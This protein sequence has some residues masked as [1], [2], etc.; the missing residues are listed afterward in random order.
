[1][2]KLWFAVQGI[3]LISLV[4][5][6]AAALAVYQLNLI[7]TSVTTTFSLLFGSKDCICYA[8]CTDDDADDLK[9]SYEL[10]FG[11]DEFNKLIDT[12]VMESQYKESLQNMISNGSTGKEIGY[13]IIGYL[14]ED[15]VACYKELVGNNSGFMSS[16]G[17]DR[18]KMTDD[19]LMADLISLLKDYKSSGRN[20]E[21]TV[22]STAST[23]LLKVKCQGEKHY[24]EGWTWESLWGSSTTTTTT[25]TTTTSSNYVPG[26]ATGQYAVKLVDGMY[27]W[28]HQSSASCGCTYCGTWSMSKWG[29]ASDVNSKDTF[30]KNGCAVY[31]LAIGI[32][33]LVGQEITPTV[34]LTDLGCEIDGTN[35]KTDNSSN[36]TN[37]SIYRRSALN[38]LCSKYDLTYNE[39]SGTTDEIIDGIDDVLSK[40]GYIWTQWRDSEIDWANG[41]SKHFMIIRKQDGDN[42]YC[43]TSCRGKSNITTKTGK[44]GAIDTMN[45]GIAKATV[46]SAIEGSIW[47]II[48]NQQA[49][50]TTVN[51]TTSGGTTSAIPVSNG[52]P[53]QISVTADEV[54]QDILNGL[55]S[56]EDYDYL[57]SIRKEA[58]DYW[59]WYAVFCV[60]RN[61][62]NLNTSNTIQQVVS[63]AN[64]F[65]AYN[66]AHIGD[67]DVND[68]TAGST[69]KV[70]DELRSAA[71][72]VLRGGPDIVGGYTRFRGRESYPGENR[73]YNM[74]AD[75][76]IENFYNWGG[77][78]FYKDGTGK[79]VHNAVETVANDGILIYE[80]STGTWYYPSGSSYK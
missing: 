57:L 44:D 47:G 56:Q 22:C 10:L 45:Y 49:T 67:P 14:N 54:Q 53:E 20:P 31:S 42:Y 24:S 9:T 55:Y 43:F 77:N 7:L 69:E 76:G 72:A 73:C 30:G 58:Q 17:K 59:G 18:T 71:V 60:V 48:P 25:T 19:E 32:S 3:A 78:L 33:N 79:V 15:S 21:C 6:I 16:D 2:T 11:T 65:Q 38:T 36:F 61:R 37:V 1:M 80:G 46:V 50:S 52:T 63:A 62:H 29:N 27:Y 51:G 8:L 23:L 75:A 26:N 40:G 12:L 70:P 74:W 64:Q 68:K 4:V 66:I 13:Y 41:T 5:C 28:Y 34:V 35:V 39:I